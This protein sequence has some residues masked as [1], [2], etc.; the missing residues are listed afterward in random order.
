[1]YPC[2]HEGRG[3][4]FLSQF[5]PPPN[6]PH[7]QLLLPTYALCAYVRFFSCSNFSFS[8]FVHVPKFSLFVHKKFYVCSYL[9]AQKILC[10]LGLTFFYILQQHGDIFNFCVGSTPSFFFKKVKFH[11]SVLGRHGDSSY[12]RSPRKRRW[13][14][15][16]IPLKAPLFCLFPK[17][18]LFCAFSVFL[19]TRKNS[20]RTKKRKDAVLS[21]SISRTWRVK[22]VGVAVDGDPPVP[23]LQSKLDLR[24]KNVPT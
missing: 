3:K 10:R 13:R 19:S 11:N 16:G 17:G 22:G 6:L 9:V 21:Y 18:A 14:Q 15:K 8:L 12:R 20:A 1:M 24:Q 7:A 5:I 2:I 23:P 4:N